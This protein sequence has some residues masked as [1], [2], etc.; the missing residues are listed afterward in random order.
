MD[1]C[2]STSVN[3]NKVLKKG[4]DK[5]RVQRR[6]CGG[7][8]LIAEDEALPEGDTREG[9]ASFSNSRTNR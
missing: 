6:R 4:K 9:V 3:E 5:Y 2:F 7:V 8:G 1:I